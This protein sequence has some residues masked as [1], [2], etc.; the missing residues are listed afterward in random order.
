METKLRTYEEYREFFTSG[1]MKKPERISGITIL[2]AQGMLCWII[3]LQR[4]DK[5]SDRNPMVLPARM[6]EGGEGDELVLLLATL[7]GG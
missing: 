3:W 6:D 7:I 1:C 2:L 4:V 5:A